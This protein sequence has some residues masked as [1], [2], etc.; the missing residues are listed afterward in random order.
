MAN[1]DAEILGAVESALRENPKASVDELFEVAKGVDPKVGKL[2]KR[3][4]HARYP[5]QVKRKFAPAKPRRPRR[6]PSPKRPRKSAG[7]AAPVREAVRA[8]LLRF[9]SDLAGAEARK[10]VVRV[11]AGVD[12]Y[13]DEVLKAVGKG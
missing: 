1:S 12:R 11:V 7:P 2:T 13:V 3:Q 6:E 4:F 9:A 8:S 10:D 5:L